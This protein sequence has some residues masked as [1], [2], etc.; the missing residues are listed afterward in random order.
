MLTAILI[1]VAYLGFVLFVAKVAAGND[2]KE[3]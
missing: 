2:D 1:L 3:A